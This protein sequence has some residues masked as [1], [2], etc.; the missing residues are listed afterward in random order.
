M[1]DSWKNIKIKALHFELTTKCTAS[2]PFCERVMKGLSEDKELSFDVIK[3][4][5]FTSLKRIVFSGSFGEPTLH[6][7]FFEILRHIRNINKE[8]QI[9]VCTNGNSHNEEW[10]IEFGNIL[11]DKGYAVFG[12]DG[13]EDTHSLHRKGTSFKK[14]TNNIKAFNSS[15]SKS[16][17]QMIMFRHNEHQVDAIKKL[18]ID[19]GC[20]RMFTRPS[21]QY[22]EEL[23]RPQKIQVQTQ[24]DHN[25]ARDP[26]SCLIETRGEL[27]ININGYIGP[28]YL[29]SNER[30]RYKL[31]SPEFIKYYKDKIEELN[32][33]KNDLD[34]ALSSELLDYIL[35]NKHNLSSCNKVCRCDLMDLITFI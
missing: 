1:V 22:N 14:I 5:D 10:W 9:V 31:E 19:L 24:T 7:K 21:K 17:I 4:F 30:N 28:C 16:T 33:N 2:C 13:L 29:F 20:N 8:I 35:K 6:S 27:F 15:T 12:V 25:I 3:K 26:I 18:S 11:T 23:Q 34:K 32:L